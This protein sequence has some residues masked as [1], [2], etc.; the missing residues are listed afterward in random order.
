MPISSVVLNSNNLL[1]LP[2]TFDVQVN[3]APYSRFFLPINNGANLKNYQIALQKANVNY[4]WPNV[5]SAN[6]IFTIEWDITGVFTSFV[7][8]IPINTNYASI[9][10]LNAWLQSFCITNGLY[11]VTAA[12]VNVYYLEFVANPNYYGVSLNLYLVPTS[13]PATYVQP[14]NF[15]GYPSVSHTPKISFP[16]TTT[17]NKLI[18]FA[19]NTIFYGGTVAIS[20]ISSFTPQLSPIACVNIS[21]NIAFNPL[22]LNGDSSVMNT[23]VTGT[24]AY[25]STIEIEPSELTWFDCNAGSSSSIQIEFRD[26]N[27]AILNIRDPDT[28]VV[29]LLRDNPDKV[30]F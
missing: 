24:T 2:N 25:G 22:S 29:L 6:N 19:N 30:N 26:Q 20:Y 17:F 23:F 21:C 12:G 13:L 27:G 18:G 16:T 9:S 8:T 15:A 10:E 1:Q 4:S 14:S 3:P 5:T 11:L 28:S 7:A